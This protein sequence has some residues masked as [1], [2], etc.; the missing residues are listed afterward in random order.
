MPVHDWTRVEAGVFHEFTP[1][2]SEP[3]ARF[4]TM[5]CCLPLSDLSA[6]LRCRLQHRAPPLG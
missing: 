1:F 6:V 2:G 3:S 4:L 5:V